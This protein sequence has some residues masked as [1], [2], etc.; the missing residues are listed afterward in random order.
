MVRIKH[1]YLLVNILYPE[2]YRSRQQLSHASQSSKTP[3]TIQ[4]HSPTSDDLTPQILAR[5]IRD[6]ILYMYGDYG[7]GITSTGLNVKYLSPAT[8]T[9]IIRCSR[10]NYQLVWAALTFLTHIP[11]LPNQPTPQPCV[12]Q[13]VRVSGTIRKAEEEIIKRARAAI[14]AARNAAH[15]EGLG[16]LNA[17]LGLGIAQPSS[18]SHADVSQLVTGIEDNDEDDDD[19]DGDDGDEEG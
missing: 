16:G 9:A 8:S 6:Q 13:V 2:P 15:H 10:A 12:M 1:R 4:F 3:E 17:I 5:A 7:L 18:I 19:G 14:L 11:Q